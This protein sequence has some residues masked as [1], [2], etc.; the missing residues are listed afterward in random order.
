MMLV[1]TTP[2]PESA[3]P[4]AQLKDHLRLGSGFA[5]DDVQDGLLAGHLRAAMGAIEARTG[6]ILIARQFGWT[7]SAWRDATAQ[8]LP[9][10]PVTEVT[11]VVLTAADGAETEVPQARWMLEQD[12]HRPYLMPLGAMLPT[13]PRGGTV[14]IAL[15]AGYGPLWSD[16]PADL[17]QAVIMLAAH[18]YENRH[19]VAQEVPGLPAPVVALI[20]GHRSLRLFMGGGYA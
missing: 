7:L 19:S 11:E 8:P 4:V 12:Q 13:V 20:E 18:Y 9:V 6:K 2:V 1:E 10:A 15:Q 14:R 16:L 3:V 5:D 17:A